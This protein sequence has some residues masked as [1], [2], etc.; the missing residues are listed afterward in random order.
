MVDF[1]TL[2]QLTVDLTWVNSWENTPRNCSPSLLIRIQGQMCNCFLYN[3]FY[4]WNI[5][6]METMSD[7]I[8][9][10][11]YFRDGVFS[12]LLFH[13]YNSITVS[14]WLSYLLCKYPMTFRVLP[15]SCFV[16]SKLLLY[17]FINF[18]GLILDIRKKTQRFSPETVSPPQFSELSQSCRFSLLCVCWCQVAPHLVFPAFSL[19]WNKSRNLSIYI[20]KLVFPN[21]VFIS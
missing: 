18:H 1:E 10:Y 8:P 9:H 20:N 11:T 12:L 17:L 19:I 3:N 2:K 16:F 13:K 14:G 7:S 15:V 21:K 6:Y 4:T 5:M